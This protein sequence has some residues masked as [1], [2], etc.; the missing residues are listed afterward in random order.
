MFLL[1]FGKGC[2]SNKR[3]QMQSRRQ[4][5]TAGLFRIAE[6]FALSVYPDVLHLC[7]EH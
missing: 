6:R 2:F 5:H 7:C 4:E 3:K 1:H